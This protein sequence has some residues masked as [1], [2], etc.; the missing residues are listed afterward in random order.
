[1]LMRKR[2][3][4]GETYTRQSDLSLVKFLDKKGKE[5][6]E[7]LSEEGKLILIPSVD[8]MLPTIDTQFYERIK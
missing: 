8:L 2:P 7:V 3:I 1:M 4:R 6:F 5:H